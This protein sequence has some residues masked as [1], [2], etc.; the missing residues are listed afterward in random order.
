MLYNE[1]CC[2]LCSLSHWNFF[3]T[4]ILLT[5]SGKKSFF[6]LS[7]EEANILQSFLQAVPLLSSQNIRYHKRIFLNSQV[8]VWFQKHLVPKHLELPILNYIILILISINITKI[9]SRNFFE[10]C[11]NYPSSL[12]MNNQSSGFIAVFLFNFTLAI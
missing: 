10:H 8:H 4:N 9:F 2:Q 12:R 6:F 11:E 7:A 3:K 5:L 1:W